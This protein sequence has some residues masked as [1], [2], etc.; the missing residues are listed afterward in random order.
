MLWDANVLAVSQVNGKVN[1]YRVHYK[2]WSTRFD[3]WVENARV[4][5]P[6]ENN[7]Q[8]QDE[9]TED[10]QKKKSL[11]EIPKCKFLQKLSAKAFIEAPNRARGNL[12]P[13]NFVEVATVTLGSSSGEET[14]QRLK[15]AMLMME[16]ALPA[17]SVDTGPRGDWRPEYSAAWRKTVIEASGPYTLMA[18]AYYLEESIIP[19]W[20]DQHITHVLSSLPQRWKAIRE[21]SHA[22]LAL[23]ISMLDMG[24]DY[25]TVELKKPKSR[26]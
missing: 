13:P 9:M 10:Q 17:G 6:N 19:E 23:R 14:F 11:M 2:G 7:V 25:E 20:I 5:E 1:G 18:C 16:A 21:A 4:V 15:A 26:R 22:S 24:L 8:V 3:E 12:C